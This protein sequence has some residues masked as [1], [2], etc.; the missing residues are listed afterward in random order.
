MKNPKEC[1]SL[2]Q[3]QTFFILN[4]LAPPNCEDGSEPLLFHHDTFSRFVFVIINASKKAVKANIPVS[5]IPAIIEKIRNLNFWDSI[6]LPSIQ[7]DRHTEAKSPAYTTIISSGTL[8]GKTPAAALLEDASKNKMLL[9][10]QNKWLQQNLSRYPRNQEQITAIEDALTL[11]TTGKLDTRL[12]ASYPMVETIY[13]AEMRP[14]IRRKRENGKCFV[15]EISIAWNTGTKKPLEIAI[16]NYYAPVTQTESGLLNV[17]V[18]Q[19]EDE[20]K[21]IFFLTPEEAMWMLHMLETN[22]STFENIY[23]REH[24][25]TANKEERKTLEEVRKLKSLASKNIS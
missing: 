11:F 4:R 25:E 16:R 10:N 8:K 3:N 9:L 5:A 6:L 15:Y 12:T 17:Q 2:C 18:Q 7:T 24:Y 22:I 14:L 1:F 23:A 13:H 20:L 21:N 19:R